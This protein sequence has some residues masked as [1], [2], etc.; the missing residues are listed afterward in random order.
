MPRRNHLSQSLSSLL[1]VWALIHL[2]IAWHPLKGTA[3][4][5]GG[6]SQSSSEG[7]FCWD[8]MQAL[9]TDVKRPLWARNPWETIFSLTSEILLIVK[10]SLSIIDMQQEKVPASI[11]QSLAMD[12]PNHWHCVLDLKSGHYPSK[13]TYF[14][15]SWISPVREGSGTEMKGTAVAFFLPEQCTDC[16]RVV[17]LL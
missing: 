14:H 10:L 11:P 17:G 12:V 7:S 16:T 1:L 15:M 6:H 8:E 3:C 2:V 9:G 5:S 13:Q 4:V